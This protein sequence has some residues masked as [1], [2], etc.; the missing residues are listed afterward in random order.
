M[1]NQSIL[2]KVIVYATIVVGLICTCVKGTEAISRVLML[3]PFC[4]MVS[5]IKHRDIDK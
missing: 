4:Y 2:A 1:K 5:W 3:T